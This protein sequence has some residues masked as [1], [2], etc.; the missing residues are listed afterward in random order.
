MVGEEYGKSIGR[1]TPSVH[2]FFSN[3]GEIMSKQD[4]IRNSFIND[5]RKFLVSQTK[6]SQCS[7]PCIHLFTN[8]NGLSNSGML[9]LGCIF[10]QCALMCRFV[11]ENVTVLANVHKLG[12]GQGVTK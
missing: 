8:F 9:F 6:V 2:I 1:S 5:G 4:I 10:C 7:V 11:N 12:V 3:F